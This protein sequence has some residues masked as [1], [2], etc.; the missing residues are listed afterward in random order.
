MKFKTS[1]ISFFFSFIFV[2]IIYFQ[3]SGQNHF[4]RYGDSNA[5]E[6]KLLKFGEGGGMW[7]DV[8]KPGILDGTWYI[9]P[10]SKKPDSSKCQINYM[11]KVNVKN[12]MK[13]GIL[14]YTH[15]FDYKTPMLQLNYLNDT[16]H[17]FYFMT[18]FAGQKIEEGYY[19]K[20][21]KHGM[22]IN[23]FEKKDG[24]ESIKELDFFQYDTLVYWQ[25]YNQYEK[26]RANGECIYPNKSC[27]CVY[28]DTLGRIRTKG[29]FNANQE[30]IKVEY[31]DSNSNIEKEIIGDFKYSDKSKFSNPR[32]RELGLGLEGIDL[33]N[34]KVKFYSKGI[35][36]KEITKVPD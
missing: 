22:F 3:S 35:L 2:F 8:F 1:S 5:V 11:A 23:Y 4:I 15:P 29:F 21:K 10:P 25:C 14:E 36:I 12:G 6:T 31:F 24:K 27:E 34:G 26:I 20:G 13:Q 7:R 33:I 18:G 9:C 17:G 32:L 30:L 28:Y 19:K 16:L